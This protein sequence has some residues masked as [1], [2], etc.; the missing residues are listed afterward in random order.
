M[1]WFIWTIFCLL[2]LSASFTLIYLSFKH[3]REEKKKTMDLLKSE[4]AGESKL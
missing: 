4:K 3:E 1:T 2:V